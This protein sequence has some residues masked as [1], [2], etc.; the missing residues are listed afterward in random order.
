[1]ELKKLETKKTKGEASSEEAKPS[2]PRITE[3]K[4]FLQD[5]RIEFEKIHW[6]ARKEA[7]ALSAAVLFLTIFFTAYLGIVD[8][9]LSRLVGL[10]LG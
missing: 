2:S 5:V 1:M 6:P 7:V 10:L 9:V 4:E 8:G 3:A